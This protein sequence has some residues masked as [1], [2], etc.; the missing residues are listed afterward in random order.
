MR[1]FCCLIVFLLGT[2]ECSFSKSLKRLMVEKSHS[3]LARGKNGK[4]K[5]KSKK[6]KETV[7][8]CFIDEGTVTIIRGQYIEITCAEQYCLES[9]DGLGNFKCIDGN[10]QPAAVCMKTKKKKKCAGQPTEP[11]TTTT[12][13]TTTTTTTTSTTST[14][15]A[16][17]NGET[18]PMPDDEEERGKKPKTTKPPT[19]STTTTTSMVVAAIKVTPY[20]KCPPPRTRIMS[21]KW[22]DAW[23]RRSKYGFA[24][25]I[26]V[27]A[28][29]VKMAYPGYAKIIKKINTHKLCK[30][31]CTNFDVY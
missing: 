21:V 28:R 8:S 12:T 26:T 13:A 31:L 27:P 16:T 17:T 15:T 10:I 14:T 2:A 25:Q 23:K 19:T 6:P 29:V 18:Q 24:L 1:L 9:T 20:Q 5:K 11:P 22:V 3:E 7:K 30:N 4:S